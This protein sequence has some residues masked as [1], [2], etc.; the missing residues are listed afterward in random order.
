L[1]FPK[2]V[3]KAP[4]GCV[5]IATITPDM[6][7]KNTS[8]TPFSK[9]KCR[10]CQGPTQVESGNERKLLNTGCL[11]WSCKKD[12][13]LGFALEAPLPFHHNDCW[14][15]GEVNQY[16]IVPPAQSVQLTTL[17]KT[18]VFNHLEQLV[19][20]NVCAS[21]T[22]RP[23]KDQDSICTFC[24]SLHETDLGALKVSGGHTFCQFCGYGLWHSDKFSLCQSDVLQDHDKYDIHTKVNDKK[25]T[26]PHRDETHYP[27]APNP[28]IQNVNKRFEVIPDWTSFWAKYKGAGWSVFQLKSIHWQ[29]NHRAGH[30][31]YRDDGIWRIDDDGSR[32]AET[33]GTRY[34]DCRAHLIKINSCSKEELMSLPDIGTQ[35]AERIML[36]RKA[37]PFLNIRDIVRRAGNATK[38]HAADRWSFEKASGMLP[39][40]TFH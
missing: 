39:F 8:N 17:A 37:G 7:G 15:K 32:Y 22:L 10:E 9:P 38:S 35:R 31:S 16:G 5:N 3:P 1:E 26:Y 11:L 2:A 29:V 34:I 36:A 18:S 28:K 21:C 14:E 4:P 24:S 19:P 13:C 40:V 6:F 23:V 33:D 27:T 30:L 12:K 25:R 20:W